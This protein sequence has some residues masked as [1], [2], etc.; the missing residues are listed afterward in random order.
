M[1]ISRTLVTPGSFS[2]L[3][4]AVTDDQFINTSVLG[5]ATATA[6]DV[7]DTQVRVW[8]VSTHGSNFTANPLALAGVD[9]HNGN[10]GSVISLQGHIDDVNDALADVRMDMAPGLDGL[11]PTTITDTAHVLVDDFGQNGFC[12][13]NDLPGTDPAP[14]ASCNRYDYAN[15]TVVR[16]SVPL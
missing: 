5:V 6:L 10:G 11:T 3:S 16:R 12:D 9:T 7:D 14:R 15:Q 8:L 13:C 2:R 4:I 1:S